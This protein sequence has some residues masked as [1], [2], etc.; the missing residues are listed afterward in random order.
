MTIFS[1]LYLKIILNNNIISILLKAN[2][3]FCLLF[4]FTK[5][6]FI[7]YIM[8]E[9]AVYPIL[10]IISIFGYQI[11]RLQASTFFLGYTLFFSIPRIL[12]FIFLQIQFFNIENII[13]FKIRKIII[14]LIFIIFSVKLPLFLLHI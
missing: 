2:L 8:F 6:T 9:F 13:Y 10:L 5:N 1:F 4:F 3:I 12:A 14:F 7:F 11:E